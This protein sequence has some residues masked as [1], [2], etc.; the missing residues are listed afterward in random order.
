MMHL[1][2]LVIK[3][4]TCICWVVKE[5]QQIKMR[6]LGILGLNQAL[7]LTSPVTSGKSLNLSNPQLP[8]L[9]SGGNNSAS[10][11]ELND[12]ILHT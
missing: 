6:V 2:R 9:Q 8:Q 12:F 1:D 11:R 3:T 7:S 5:L 10:L 4:P